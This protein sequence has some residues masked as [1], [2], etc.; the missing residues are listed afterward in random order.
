MNLT[1]KLSTSEAIKMA[2]N[3]TEY[4]VSIDVTKLS[5]KQRNK[6]NY[7]QSGGV[8]KWNEILNSRGEL[9]PE[10]IQLLVDDEEKSNEEKARKTE[11]E[12]IRWLGLS[13]GKRIEKG[14]RSDTARVTGLYSLPEADPR[15]K[16]EKERLLKICKDID[17]KKLQELENEKKMNQD[18]EERKQAQLTEIV[19]NFGT[20]IQKKKWSAGM[21]ERKEVLGLLWKNT[22]I[23]DTPFKTN[24]P[25]YYQ[26]K[27]IDVD[28]DDGI[29]VKEEKIEKLT[30]EEFESLEHIKEWYPDFD[31]EIWREVSFED[32]ETV[33]EYKFARLSK[34]IGK[35]DMEADFVL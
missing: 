26:T 24:I 4:Q 8:I 34:K 10:S 9:T 14:G 22:F 13:D 31:V 30:D 5:E 35:Y 29:K 33:D 3:E 19:N 17:N 21:M 7:Y 20:D 27:N 15:I 28:E 16:A 2:K 32:G 6:L 12:I 23:H 25:L 11:E 1:V 18:L